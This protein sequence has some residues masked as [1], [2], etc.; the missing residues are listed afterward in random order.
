[1]LEAQV[2]LHSDPNN[3]WNSSYTVVKYDCG[4][5]MSLWNEGFIYNRYRE[6]R[7]EGVFF[8]CNRRGCGALSYLDMDEVRDIIIAKKKV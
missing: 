5:I 2:Q 7:G 8:L 4:K 3:V 6:F 1:L